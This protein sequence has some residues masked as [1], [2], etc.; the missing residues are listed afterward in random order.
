MAIAKRLFAMMA[1]VFEEE[2]DEPSDAYVERL[3]A[4]QQ[5]WALA[6]WA[7]EELVGGITAHELPMTSAAASELFVYDVAVRADHH[8]RGVG[9]AL[10]GKLRELA[11]GAGFT[12]VFLLV[13]EG[14]DEALD[15]YRA[16]GGYAAPV[17]VVTFRP[18][19]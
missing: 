9:R 17:T 4:T 1:R 12:D 10:V 13:E 19:G 5:F 8:R 11:G 3:L 14:D 7:G 6:A 2:H 16:V 18:R 15:F